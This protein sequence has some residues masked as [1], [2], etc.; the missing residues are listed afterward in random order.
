[1]AQFQ[2][3]PFE[4]INL[5]RAPS[6]SQQ[7]AVREVRPGVAGVTIYRMGKQPMPYQVLSVCDVED[8]ATGLLLL[9]DYESLVGT[10]PVELYWAG[11]FSS[12]VYVHQVQPIDGGIYQTLLGV[13]GILG[14]SNGM[15]RAVW[16]LEEIAVEAAQ[17]EQQ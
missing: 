10:D 12:L 8:A 3:G 5:S 15:I 2:I 16:T 7:T 9:E 11:V 4:F 13:G 14:S 17:Q 1:M 6:R